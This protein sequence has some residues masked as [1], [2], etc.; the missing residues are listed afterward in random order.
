YSQAIHGRTTG[1]GTGIIDTLQLVDV[2]RGAAAIENSGALS[3][4]DR[5]ALRRWFE[6]YLS[7]MSTSKNG[8]EEREAK[9]NHG[10]CWILQAAVFA[11]Y[12]GDS[13]MQNFCR[14]RFRT[15][16]MPNQMASD[17]SFPL[18]LRRTKPY[19]YSLFNLEAMAGIC[20]VLSTSG[21]DLW[22]Y[23]L[24]DGR[25]MARAEAFMYPYIADKS[26]WPY[27]HDVMYFDVWPLREQS[28]LFAGLALDRPEYLD[29]WKK[30]NENPVVEEAIR[31]Y[32]IRQPVLWMN[33]AI[34]RK[35]LVS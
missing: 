30:L 13:H 29:L 27:P 12:T 3:H 23:T 7:W 17:G 11:A 15:V 1:R 2:V 25:G 8:I 34:D 4:D 32:P 28:L 24:P 6:Y 33:A 5:I 10:T 20:Q 31:N 26:K 22:T 19:S 18:E 14:D 16:L 21:D 35:V 9:N